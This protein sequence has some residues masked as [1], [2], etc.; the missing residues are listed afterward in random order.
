MAEREPHAFRVPGVSAALLE[1]PID[2]LLAEHERHRALCLFLKETAR[3]GHID[4]ESATNAARFLETDLKRHFDDERLLFYPALVQRSNRDTEFVLAI[5]NVERVHA[6]TEGLIDHLIDLLEGMADSET[7]ILPDALQEIFD[8]YAAQELRVLAYENS[9]IMS[10][11][12]VRLR[13]GDLA[14]IGEGLKARRQG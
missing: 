3:S 7:G 14:K 1:R 4:R 5:R 2:Y 8:E 12:G 9:V 10:I 13:R 11:A 6:G